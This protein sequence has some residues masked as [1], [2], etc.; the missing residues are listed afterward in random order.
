[1]QATIEQLTRVQV[2]KPLEIDQLEQLQSQCS[3]KD[4][5]RGEIVMH[6]GDR[7]PAL[8]Y[9]LIE[10][11]LQIKKTASTG[12][13]TLVRTIYPGEIFAAPA[14]FGNGIAPATVSAEVDSQVLTV[15]REALLETIRQNP[16]VALRILEVFNQRLQQLHD[17]VHGLVSERAIARLVRLIQYYAA[18]YGTEARPEGELLKVKLSY[19]QMARSIGI[20]YEECVRLLASLKPAIAYK[21]GGKI[22]V[23]DW[24][25]IEASVFE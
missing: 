16:D 23:R 9:T 22:L 12:K 4:Y 14:V 3:V 13:E 21:R 20:T 8:L 6:E 25:A 2:L 18:R 24:E 1:V 5:Q 11:T 10:G 19:Y 15:K 17:T 7:L